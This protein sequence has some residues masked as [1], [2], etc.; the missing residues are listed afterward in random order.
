MEKFSKK[1]LQN[2][3]KHNI[4]SKVKNVKYLQILKVG[5]EKS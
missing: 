3:R 2:F 4:I 5:G 1:L